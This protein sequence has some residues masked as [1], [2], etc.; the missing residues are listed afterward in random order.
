MIHAVTTTNII[1]AYDA[2]S[3]YFTSL[4]RQHL[5]SLA[6]QPT[7]KLRSKN[8][9]F[10]TLLT[11]TALLPLATAYELAIDDIGSVNYVAQRVA[12]KMMQYY[13]GN[14]TGGI[15]GL[16]GDPYY[17]WES[18]AVFGGLV[19]Y[20]YYTGD[21]GYNPVVTEA[22]LHQ[23][24]PDWDY[25]PPNQSK[26]LGNDD[27]CFWGLTVISA[28]EKNFP[29]PPKDKAQWL[30]LAQAVFN[31]QAPRWDANTCGGGLRWQIYTFNNGYS[32]KNT[33]SN[34]CF[35]QLAARL[36]RYTGNQTYADWAEKAYD[37]TLESGLST[38]DYRFF[39]GS[40]TQ[41]N[42]T[43]IN[44]VQWSYNAGTYLAGA[45][46]MYNYTDGDPLWRARVDGIL[47][48]SNRIFFTHPDTGLA[49]IMVEQACERIMTC[50]IDQRSFK[51]YFARFLALTV[52]MAPYT[53]P[54]IIPKLRTSAMAAA[55]HCS[56]GTDANSCGMKWYENDW[57]GMYGVGEQLSALEVIQN[58]L[59][60]DVGIPV[61][62]NDGGT[63]KGDPSA[64]SQG[65]PNRGREQQAGQKLL[66]NIGRKDKILAW[67]STGIMILVTAVFGYWV[68]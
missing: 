45:A 34:G 26:S 6:P 2:A 14:R 53:A 66:E 40:D 44:Y 28:A 41:S 60:H 8:W 57:D 61:T 35:F 32:Y 50:N 4:S 24:G 29:D 52:K 36:A 43:S 47:D 64:G 39:D 42:C 11:I 63:S 3:A 48:M 12:Y 31:T 25:M 27:Q 54:L 17:W 46:Y 62:E 67:A 51:A 30:A 37:W 65:G 22:L 19:D 20:W 18:G 23:I 38:A 49:D 1:T 10:V 58:T 7:M 21:A 16:F 5:T 55:R 56:W 13:P 33:I 68:Y 15:P 9:S 59:I